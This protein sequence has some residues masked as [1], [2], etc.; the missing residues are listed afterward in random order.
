MNLFMNGRTYLSVELASRLQSAS[1]SNHS[2]AMPSTTPTYILHPPNNRNCMPTAVL[3]QY[4]VQTAYRDD[5][6]PRYNDNHTRTLSLTCGCCYGNFSVCCFRYEDTP[7]V[8]VIGGSFITCI[9]TLCI[10]YMYMVVLAI[11]FC[12]YI[13]RPSVIA[14]LGALCSSV[15]FWQLKSV[16]LQIIVYDISFSCKIQVLVL[17]GTYHEWDW[18]MERRFWLNY[19]LRRR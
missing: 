8:V 15:G 13:V 11:G 7:V 14:L 19:V 3:H 9:S 12:S 2:L 18:T 6:T 1:N 16:V 17:G 5:Y 4:C 10:L